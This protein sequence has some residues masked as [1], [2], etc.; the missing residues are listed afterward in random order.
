MKH[1]DFRPLCSEAG[2]EKCDP[3]DENN[4][5]PWKCGPFKEYVNAKDALNYNLR[6]EEEIQFGRTLMMQRAVLEHFGCTLVDPKEWDDDRAKQYLI[7]QEVVA[8]EGVN[9][10]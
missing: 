9:N 2:V 10:G 6:S 3:A 1:N 8:M 5:N 4:L 7:Y